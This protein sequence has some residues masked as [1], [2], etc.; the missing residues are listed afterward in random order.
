[1]LSFYH[2][3]DNKVCDHASHLLHLLLAMKAMLKFFQH[4]H[5]HQSIPMLYQIKRFFSFTKISFWLRSLFYYC[6]F[7]STGPDGR[8]KN[9]TFF[10]IAFP[11]TNTSYMLC[12]LNENEINIHKRRIKFC[13]FYQKGHTHRNSMANTYIFCTHLLLNRVCCFFIRLDIIA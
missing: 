10:L 8:K 7:F 11:R 5:S 9:N 6:F 13:F 3:I 4:T 2:M 1:M 12:V